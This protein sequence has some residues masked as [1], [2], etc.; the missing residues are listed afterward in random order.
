VYFIVLRASGVALGGVAVGLWCGLFLWGT[1]ATLVEGLPTWDAEV[2][3]HLA[4]LLVV[5]TLVGSLLP[6]WRTV[7]ATPMR[8]VGEDV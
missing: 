6:T 3:L 2:A 1:L 5:A 8:L 4:P 7:R